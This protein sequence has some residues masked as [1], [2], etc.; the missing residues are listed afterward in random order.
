M[1]LIGT[2][3]FKDPGKDSVKVEDID[4]FAEESQQYIEAFSKS[5]AAFKPTR[6]LLE[7]RECISRRLH[8]P[9][10]RGCA[11]DR[12]SRVAISS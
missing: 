10:Q 7:A 4:I 1:M 3:H 2:F 12:L 5:L 9:Y 8:C 11:I 6:I